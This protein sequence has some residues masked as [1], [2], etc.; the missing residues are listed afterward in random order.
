M[1]FVRTSRDFM[2]FDAASLA[3]FSEVFVGAGVGVFVGFGVGV[4]VAV[5]GFADLIPYPGG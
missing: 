4:F 5:G 3:A 1:V 2:N